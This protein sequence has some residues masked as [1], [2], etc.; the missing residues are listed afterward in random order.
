MPTPRRNPAD[1][2]LRARIRQPLHFPDLSER[3]TMRISALERYVARAHFEP[4][5]KLLGRPDFQGLTG[6]FSPLTYVELA[7]EDVP[8]TFDATLV[9]QGRG[10][11]ART[12]DASGATRHLI[13][14]GEHTVERADGA[15]IGRARMVN[16]FTRYDP[17]PARRRVEDVIAALGFPAPPARVAEVPTL[18]DLVPRD[19][20]PDA[21]DPQTHVWHLGNTD[22]NRHVNGMEYLR[23]LEHF[24]A[25][26]L[27]HAGHDLR[28][29]WAA[30]ARIVFRKPCFRGEGYRRLAWMRS[31]AP[32]VL[33]GAIRKLGDDPEAPPAAAVEITYGRHDPTPG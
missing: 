25:D 11:M 20:A 5:H 9:V 1:R 17:D 4:W 10:W 31:E 22:A 3:L 23:T 8:C 24:L 15:L 16:T 27:F 12:V 7:V 28:T 21:V 13:R 32:L 14:D 29:L 26:V 30:R 6:V 2:V 33:A 19:R 18:H